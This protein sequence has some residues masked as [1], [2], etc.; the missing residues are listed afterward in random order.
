MHCVRKLLLWI[1]PL[2]LLG[3]LRT[4]AAD[5]HFEKIERFGT[6]QHQ[7]LL[8]FATIKQRTTA[9]QYTENL[10]P[11]ARWITLD[12]YPPYPEPLHYV[13]LD[14]P[15]NRFRFYRLRVTQ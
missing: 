4:E 9:L 13:V 1:V 11:P 2:A 10:R 14:A 6:N 8:H 15:T 12:T 7:V 5:P 3:S